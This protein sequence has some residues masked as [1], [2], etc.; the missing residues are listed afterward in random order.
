MPAFAADMPAKAPP[1]VQQSWDGFY[2]GG[3]VGYGWGTN[4]KVSYSPNDPESTFIF[5]TGAGAPPPVSFKESGALGGLQLGYNW[6]LNRNWLAGLET[7][8]DWSG[9][10]G[11]GLSAGTIAAAG[12]GTIAAPVNEQV[13]WFGT[14]RGRLGYL[15][16]N[17]LLTYV[18]GGVAYGHVSHTGSY[19]NNGPFF[20]NTIGGFTAFCATGVA[21]YA[22]SSST[23]AAGWTVGA[24]FE[25]ALGKNWSLKAEYLYVNLGSHS[26]T[27]TALVPLNPAATLSSFNANYSSTALNVARVG[28]NY[29]F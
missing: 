21:C 15:P 25:Y 8:F 3:N 24:G 17:D 16:M 11:S 5:I 12:P 29:H 9:V 28:L 18:T 4:R 26:L 10:K 23:T 2:V 13:T 27:Q 14:V 7:D 6:Q 22:G 20:G 1:A 19:V